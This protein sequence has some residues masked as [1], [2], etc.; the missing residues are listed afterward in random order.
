MSVSN[1]FPFLCLQILYIRA[2]ASDTVAEVKAKIAGFE[3]TG[4]STVHDIVLRTEWN[5]PVEQYSGTAIAKV[6]PKVPKHT[7]PE[8]MRLYMRVSNANTPCSLKSVLTQLLKRKA[9]AFVQA[10]KTYTRDLFGYDSGWS[11]SLTMSVLS[12]LL[13]RMERIIMN[14]RMIR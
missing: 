7:K 3:T 14:Y 8:G 10:R 9:Y 13:F 6:L 12:V 5:Y 4:Q 1:S 11:R 2:G